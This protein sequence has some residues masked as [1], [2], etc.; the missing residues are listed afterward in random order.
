[1]KSP[2]ME[3][4]QIEEWVKMCS[5]VEFKQSMNLVKGD[6]HLGIRG[7]Q[8]SCLSA[9]L[10]VRVLASEPSYSIAA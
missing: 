3:S 5:T 6:L 2:K 10:L 9:A 4:L 1:M 7:W 8:Y